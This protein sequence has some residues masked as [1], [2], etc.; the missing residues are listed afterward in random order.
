MYLESNATH[1][2]GDVKNLRDTMHAWIGK[3]YMKEEEMV[4]LS[5]CTKGQILSLEGRSK[6]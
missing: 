3:V 6:R 4:F 5:E 2:K 1:L